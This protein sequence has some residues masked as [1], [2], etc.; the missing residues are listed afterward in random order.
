[1][2]TI[3]NVHLSLGGHPIL[4]GTDLTIRDGECLAVVG[5]NGCGKS[6][7]LKAIA[8][9][10]TPDTGE[11]RLPNRMTVEYLPQEADLETDRSVQDEMLETF[12]EI[13]SALDEMARLEEQMGRT[14][15]GSPEH[16][17][18]LER[19]VECTHIV[20]HHDGYGIE[21]EAGRIAAG[22]GFSP[23]DMSRSCREFSGGWQMRILLA[24]LL[25]RKPDVLL[26]D[27]PTNHLDLE[28]TLW[29]EDWIKGC[30]R[31]VV[32]VTHE[33]AMID[34]L[35]DRIVCL[36]GGRADT[37]PGDYSGFVRE[38]ERKRRAQWTAYEQ[39]QSK[40][41]SM[42]Q[43]IR[44]FRATAS[45]ASLVQ[46]RIKQLDKMV[47]ID[48]PFHPT[49]IHF[50]FPPAPRSY[51]DVLTMTDL[52]HSYG[53]LR[54]FSNL[55][56]TI[57]RGE[58]IG[59]VGINGAGKSTL[60]RIMAGTERPTEGE[61]RLG[62]NVERV[63][64]AQY[65]TATLVSDMSLLEAIEA[66]A[67]RAEVGR[68][69]D[70][71]GA[72]LFSGDEVD[73]PLR[74]LSGGERTRFRLARML[75]SPANLLLLDEPTNHLDLTSRATVEKALRAYTGTVVVV[76][77]DRVFMDRVT[78]KIVEI[79]NGAIYTYPGKYSEYLAHKERMMAEVSTVDSA[80]AETGEMSAKERRIRQRQ[81]RKDHERRVRS[82][83]RSI[84]K[85]EH[86]IHKHET[87]LAELGRVMSDPDVASDFDRLA[88]LAEEHETLTH[89]H[90][91]LLDQWDSL[92][93]NLAALQATSHTEKP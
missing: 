20:E 37:Y 86:A 85:V 34:R 39:Q 19:Y 61:C 62:K 89:E 2:I 92:H 29:L 8:G 23:D 73:K 33:R 14:E 80:W 15:P 57:H 49:A 32:L 18:V 48:P 31:T 90:R 76:S 66:S 53:D 60:L 75:F 69:R 12:V 44:R 77:H 68:S 38:S 54:V 58:K 88:P 24:K 26:L 35:A 21:P 81:E 74:A 27:E 43:F 55:N 1:M 17:S 4:K 71:L 70:L 50:D 64:F 91:D 46:S 82:M 7:L 59:L 52:G 30:G 51:R 22:L 42:K 93:K 13:R 5:A 78:S 40:I 84:E 41:A 65:D 56:L 72:F 79:E 25:L 28:S 3:D 9:L 47:R 87:R 10:E 11:V 6:T 36:D 83:E 16:E 45:R 67:P 63:H